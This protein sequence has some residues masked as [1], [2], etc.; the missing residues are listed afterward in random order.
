MK[1]KSAFF[2]FT[3]LFMFTGIS[4]GGA[5]SHLVLLKGKEIKV[6][7]V[8]AANEWLDAAS[9]QISV[10][11]DLSATV[12][13]KHDGKNFLFAFENFSDAGFESHFRVPEVLLDIDH[14]GGESWNE[15][16][17]WIHASYSSCIG[18]GKYNYYDD[19]I[20]EPKIWETNLFQDKGRPAIIEMKIPFANLGFSPQNND[21]IGIAF[22][23]TDTREI[24][25]FFPLKAKM[26]K[27]ET[28]ATARIQLKN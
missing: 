15:N 13:Y 24:W 22:N 6:D 11:K 20:S 1:L 14:S 4:N 5:Q 9:L 26:G 10:A 25:N 16:D 2:Q 27:P 28:W 17:W 19:C 18:K 23:V 12:Y 21:E 8:K 3:I 7:G